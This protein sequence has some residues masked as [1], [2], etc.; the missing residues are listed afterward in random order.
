[1]TDELV[2]HKSSFAVW[3]TCNIEHNKE[4]I[5]RSF[6]QSMELV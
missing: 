5:S 3:I 6:Q 4:E 1:M 2:F